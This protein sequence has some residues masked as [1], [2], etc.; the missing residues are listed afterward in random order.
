VE[1]LNRLP[2]AVLQQLALYGYYEDLEED[3]TCKYG[4]QF[5]NALLI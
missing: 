2:S 1:Q 5:L 3:I 4:M